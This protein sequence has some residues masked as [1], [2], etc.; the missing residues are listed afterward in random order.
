MALKSGDLM[1]WNIVKLRTD[2]K[3]CQTKSIGVEA[4]Y[5]RFLEGVKDAR[6]PLEPYE[7]LPH[8]EVNLM[9]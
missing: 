5:S 1:I 4:C 2:R 8:N 6:T 3:T 7:Y 9:I